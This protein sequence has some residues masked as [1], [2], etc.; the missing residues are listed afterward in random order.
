MHFNLT[1]NNTN[2]NLLFYIGNPTPTLRFVSTTASTTGIVCSFVG[3]I[4]II[5]N[6]FMVVATSAPG[7]AYYNVSYF[8]EYIDESTNIVNQVTNT[9]SVTFS[10]TPTVL[11]YIRIY[12]TPSNALAMNNANTTKNG[13]TNVLAYLITS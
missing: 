13:L 3:I 1:S 6:E 4:D 7:T 9:G 10:S 12:N 5:T 2:N 11:D 8:I